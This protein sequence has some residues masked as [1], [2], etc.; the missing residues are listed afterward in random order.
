LGIPGFTPFY[1]PEHAEKVSKKVSRIFVVPCSPEYAERLS[2]I[3]F[4]KVEK[5]K[6]LEKLGVSIF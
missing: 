1:P 4:Y 2:C 3:A 5:E 6:D